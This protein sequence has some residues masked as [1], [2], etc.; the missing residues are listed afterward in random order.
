MYNVFIRLKNQSTWNSD[1][2]LEEKTTSSPI[3]HLEGTTF[4]KYVLTLS[5]RRPLPYH[6]ETSPLICSANQWTGFYMITASVMKEL[7]HFYDEI[8][9]VLAETCSTEIKSLIS[10]RFLSMCFRKNSILC[11]ISIIPGTF[12]IYIKKGCSK[13]FAQF[14]GKQQC[15]I[16][17]I[18]KTLR[19]F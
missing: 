12:L 17:F 10:L 19:F 16:L 14:T 7:I 5:L 18:N 6:I 8:K 3:L 11:Y 15:R 1:V 2:K 9:S 4:M 13:N